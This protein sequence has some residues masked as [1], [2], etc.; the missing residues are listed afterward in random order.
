[1]TIGERIKQERE[2]LGLTQSDVAKRVGCAIQTVFKYENGIVTNIPLDKISKIANALDVTP[3]YLMGWNDSG[4]FQNNLPISEP[5]NDSGYLNSSYN[6]TSL[7]GGYATYSV[8]N[9]VSDFNV[10]TQTGETVDVPFSALSGHSR[11]DFF[12]MRVKGDSM[13]PDY[14]DGDKVLVLRKSSVDYSGQTGVVLCDSDDHASLKKIEFKEGEEWI[15]IVSVNPAYPVRRI[16]NAN[17]E[18]FKILGIP[19]LLIREIAD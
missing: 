15:R 10:H 8:L 5:S 2:K 11:D 18:N 3:A 13:Y 6:D 9:D 7:K 17:A 4:L 16:E 19:K 1:M 14:K 12:V